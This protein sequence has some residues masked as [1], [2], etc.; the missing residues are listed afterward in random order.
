MIVG[1]SVR[2]F[3]TP[4]IILP[5]RRRLLLLLRKLVIQQPRPAPIVFGDVRL[6][7]RLSEYT[8]GGYQLRR[9][10]TDHP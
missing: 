7:V 3:G 4:R 8:P 1:V 9:V 10:D 2:P 5:R 6:C